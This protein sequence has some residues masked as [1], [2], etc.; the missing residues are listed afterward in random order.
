MRQLM[1]KSR[2]KILMPTL[3]LH[4]TKTKLNS[5]EEY[6][7]SFG[8][9]LHERTDEP[10]FTIEDAVGQLKT[11]DP[12]RTDVEKAM[13]EFFITHLPDEVVK[14]AGDYQNNELDEDAIRRQMRSELPS[15]MYRT[16]IRLGNEPQGSSRKCSVNGIHPNLKKQKSDLTLAFVDSSPQVS[17]LARKSEMGQKINKMRTLA[18]SKHPRNDLAPIPKNQGQLPVHPR[19]FPKAGVTMSPS[20]FKRRYSK[21][22]SKDPVMMTEIKAI[23]ANTPCTSNFSRYLKGLDQNDT[24]SP[25]KRDATSSSDLE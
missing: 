25:V 21:D 3:V 8:R 12:S 4:L 5:S 22:F 19:R 6:R 24:I 15:R 11:N 16:Q 1:V 2:H 18:K 7:S 20:S 10:V 14:A 13:D 17:K 9:N 23:V